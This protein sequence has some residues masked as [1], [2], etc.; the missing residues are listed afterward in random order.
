MATGSRF[1]GANELS[2]SSGRL[3]RNVTETGEPCYITEDG[4]AKAVIMDINKYNQLMDVIEEAEHPQ[5]VT[6][7]ENYS[8]VSVR[9][10]LD[11]SSRISS[12]RR[13]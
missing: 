2:R 13:R 8:H 12:R 1:V 7:E 4:K 6:P 3:L 5:H 11:S 9:G 10:I